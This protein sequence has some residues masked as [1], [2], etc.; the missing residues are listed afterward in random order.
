MPFILPE[1][2]AALS[3]GVSPPLFPVVQRAEL[4]LVALGLL[5]VL[6]LIIRAKDRRPYILLGLWFALPF[7]I[8][9]HNKIGVMW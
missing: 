2:L 5:A 8:I 6:V 9:P 7:V 4:A 3:S 1:Q